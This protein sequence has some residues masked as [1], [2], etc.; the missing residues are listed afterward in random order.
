MLSTYGI[1][2]TENNL[3]LIQ[4]LNDG[5]RPLIEKKPTF[6]VFEII[7]PHEIKGKI[8]TEEE[9]QGKSVHEMLFS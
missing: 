3:D 7:G 4:F 5:I 6:Y 2:I 1:A 8:V 9:L